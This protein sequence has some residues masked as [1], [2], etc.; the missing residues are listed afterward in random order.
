MIKIAVLD[1]YQNVFE[2][3]IN[4]NTYKNKFEFTVFNDHFESE[5]DRT[6]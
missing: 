4:I 2:Q 3:I 5:E 1:D 6:T